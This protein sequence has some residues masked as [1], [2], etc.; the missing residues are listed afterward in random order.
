MRGSAA[1]PDDRAD[2]RSSGPGLRR[3]LLL[4]LAATAGV[5]VLGLLAGWLFSQTSPQTAASTLVADFVTDVQAP[6]PDREAAARTADGIGCG[7]RDEPLGDRA[8]VA[9]RAGG[10]VVIVHDPALD[11]GMHDRLR[12]LAGEEQTVVVAPADGTMQRPVEARAWTHAMPLEEANLEL[13]RAFLRAYGQPG[14]P[15]CP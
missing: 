14:G 1:I 11:A 8:E 2:D 12:R 15:V 5:A 4:F 7:L 6:A 9:L 13:L 10:A 3:G